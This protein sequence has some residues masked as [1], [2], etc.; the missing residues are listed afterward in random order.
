MG[1]LVRVK[2]GWLGFGGLMSRRVDCL[3]HKACIFACRAV[4]NGSDIRFGIAFREM[5]TYLL[6]Y[7]LILV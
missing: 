2:M 1:L 5:D 6:Y 4:L 7:P 3:S